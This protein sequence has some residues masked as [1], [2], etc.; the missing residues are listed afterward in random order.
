M[1]NNIKILD[2]TLRDGGYYTGWDFDKN[3]VIEYCKLMEESPVDYVEVGYRS[4]PLNE[5]LGEYFYCPEYILKDLMPT[6]KLIIILNEKDIIVEDIKRLLESCKPYITLVRIAI[7]PKNIDRAILLAKEIKSMGFEVG[8]N[9]MYM[10]T[11]KKAPLF[12]NSLTKLDSKV[13]DYFY[14][15]D[16]YGGIMPKE[17]K[18]IVGLVKEKTSIQIG[19]HG[20]NNVEMTLINTLTA[21]ED[22]VPIVD[23]TITGTDRVWE[24]AKKNKAEIYLNIQGDEPTINPLDILNIAKEKESY[25]KHVINGMIS[26]EKNEDPQDVNIPKVLVNS[27]NELVYMSRLPIPGIKDVSNMIPIYKKQVC[28]YAYNYNELK[29]FGEANKKTKYEF[30]EDIEIL[31]F[32]DF[33][34]PIKMVETTTVSIAVD[35]KEDVEKVERFLKEKTK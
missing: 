23:A 3:L 16:S 2:C 15:V 28:I 1:I 8:F 32:F 20:H 12:L 13:I 31:R 18:E 27:K 9:V 17:L 6:K 24:V 29:I 22:G 11:W 25:P 19:S 35:I 7:D 14:M 26:L 33:S 10:S 34:I 30:Y 5:Y 4:N 21:M